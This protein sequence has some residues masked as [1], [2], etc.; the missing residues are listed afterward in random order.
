MAAGVPVLVAAVEGPD[1]RANPVGTSL[2]ARQ[3]QDALAGIDAQDHEDVVEA[4]A[5]LLYE[6]VGECERQHREQKEA[7][8]GVEGPGVFSRLGHTVL[9]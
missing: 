3:L 8:V 4:P 7:V 2:V 5:P 6:K 1:L 9:Q